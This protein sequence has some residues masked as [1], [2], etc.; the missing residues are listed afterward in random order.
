MSDDTFLT[1]FLIVLG[2]FVVGVF[3][4]LWL[5]DKKFG[6]QVETFRRM[7]ATYSVPVIIALMVAIGLYQSQMGLTCGEGGDNTAGWSCSLFWLLIPVLMISF[8]VSFWYRVHYRIS[9]VLTKV[10]VSQGSKWYN[11]RYIATLIVIL[12]FVLMALVL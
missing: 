3:W 10:G 7:F 5:L 2:V 8:V 11:A 4:G 12:L 1:V 9:Q 6:Q